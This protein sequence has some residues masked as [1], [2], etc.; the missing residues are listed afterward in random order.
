MS[1]ADVIYN[2]V[3][4]AKTKSPKIKTIEVDYEENVIEILNKYI[5]KTSKNVFKSRIEKEKAEKKAKFNSVIL[6]PYFIKETKKRE[7]ELGISIEFWSQ[8]EHDKFKLYFM[9]KYEDMCK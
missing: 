1:V 6:K 7:K 9:K 4:K 2:H 5:Y 3:V 8:K